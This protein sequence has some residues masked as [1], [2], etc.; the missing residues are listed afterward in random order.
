MPQ[1][2]KG[3]ER[4]KRILT[5]ELDSFQV[6]NICAQISPN[7]NKRLE[8]LRLYTSVSSAH[9]NSE[10]FDIVDSIDTK[11]CCYDSIV[12]FVDLVRFSNKLPC[13]NRD[14][15]KDLCILASYLSRKRGNNAA[16]IR[17]LNTHFS[18]YGPQNS[19]VD[20]CDALQ[21]GL[22][23][24]LSRSNDG[25][26]FSAAKVRLALHVSKLLFVA[27]RP[28]SA[29][30]LAT[31][32]VAEFLDKTFAP[33]LTALLSTNKKTCLNSVG[34]Y[35]EPPPNFSYSSTVAQLFHALS[36]S[37]ANQQNSINS[38]LVGGSQSMNDWS[39][40]LQTHNSYAYSINKCLLLIAKWLPSDADFGSQ[41]LSL[42][43]DS[44]LIK[45]LEEQMEAVR[46]LI[47]NIVIDRWTFLP[48]GRRRCSGH[49]I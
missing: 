49:N 32:L 12:E 33:T 30:G 39:K 31:N 14:S 11:N 18:K 48:I 41:I 9:F 43:E 27:E 16:A 17:Q 47:Y 13:V 1:L 26:S 36:S 5:E 25:D 38:S 46:K 19:D 45:L 40:S 4:A 15:E 10:I 6:M 28:R 7:W 42:S 20:P 3:T 44:L 21:N 24:C 8:A 34:G 37:T 23:S 22:I 35:H 29:F 2:D